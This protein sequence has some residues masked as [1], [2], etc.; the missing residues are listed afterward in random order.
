MNPKLISVLLSGVLCTLPVTAKA[1]ILQFN[2]ALNGA[3]E[4]PSNGATATGLATL[5]YNDN[6]SILTTDD[7]YSFSLAAFGL[8][9]VAAAMHIHAPAAPGFTASPVVNLGVSPFI[10]LNAGGTL[11]L[12][13]S[14]VTP[15]NAAFLSQLQAGLAY[16]NVHTAAFAGGEIRGQLIPVA[17][18]PEPSTYAMLLTGLA[19]MGW[20]TR[21]HA[22]AAN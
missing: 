5:F 22:K 7:T 19:L 4:V 1:L 13:G 12:G 10:S 8:T 14:N 11:L 21:R 16:V 9:G 6:N 18:V 17:A 20:T 3:S 2:T 15:P